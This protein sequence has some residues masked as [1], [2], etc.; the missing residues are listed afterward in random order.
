MA[1]ERSLLVLAGGGTGGHLYPGLAVAEEVRNRRPE[2]D[3]IVYGTPRPIDAKLTESHNLKLVVQE[4]RPLT[5]KPMQWP[6]FVRAYFKSIASAKKAF[7]ERRPDVV[8]GLGGYAAA[9]PVIAASKLGIPTAIFN[10]DA[11]PGRANKKLAGI[12][13]RVFVQWYETI[14]KFGRVSTARCTGCPIRPGFATIKRDAAIASLKLASHKK[15]IL[16][17]GASQGASS[18]NKAVI[19]L[20]DYWRSLIDWQIIHLTGATDL[21]ACRTAYADAGVDAKTLAFTEYM[22]QCMAA[23]DLIITRA[24]ASTLAEIT[25]VGRAAILMPYPFDRKQHQLANAKLLSDQNAAALVNDANE[26]KLNAKRLRRELE[27]LI[28]S[29]HRRERMAEIAGA[30]GRHDAA[31]LIS[32]GLLALADGEFDDPDD[33]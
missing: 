14:E 28:V 5:K 8:L 2:F 17:T 20:M 18:I 19:E 32:K 1:N 6:G 16:I 33:V 25:A 21:K 22:P 29:D 12:V 3:I 10:P 24:G 4:V 27:S 31:H 23:A 13:D 26:P 9:P 15:T 11:I 30:M 7:T